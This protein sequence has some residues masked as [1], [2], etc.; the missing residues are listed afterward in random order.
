MCVETR[1]KVSG[2]S[3]GNF[4]SYALHELGCRGSGRYESGREEL[5]ALDNQFSV[6]RYRRGRRY[7]ERV[8]LLLEH[9]L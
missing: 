2:K 8:E 6:F 9:P 1:V 5:W 3:A 7:V 4:R